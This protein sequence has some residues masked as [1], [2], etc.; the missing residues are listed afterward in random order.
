MIVA[1][2]TD[3]GPSRRRSA[4]NPTTS[5]KVQD[6]LR[7]DENGFIAARNP[8]KNTKRTTAAGIKVGLDASKK[9][10]TYGD[11]LLETLQ[12]LRAQVAELNGRARNN[13]RQFG[14]GTPTSGKPTAEPS[15]ALRPSSFP[16][17]G[18]TDQRSSRWIRSLRQ[19]FEVFEA[20]EGSRVAAINAL[21]DSCND[22]S[23][24][25]PRKVRIFYKEGAD[26]TYI[27]ANHTFT[28]DELNTGLEL[29]TDSRDVRR[30]SQDGKATIHLVVSDDNDQATDLV[31]LRVAPV[32]MHHHAQAVTKAFTVVATHNNSQVQFVSEC[33]GNIADAGIE[34]PVYFFSERIDRNIEILKRETGTADAEICRVPSLFYPGGGPSSMAVSILE[35]ATPPS[36]KSLARRQTSLGPRVV[37]LHPGTIN[38]V[39]VADSMVLAP[40]PWGSDINGKDT[41]ADAVSA[42]YVFEGWFQ[43]H[44]SE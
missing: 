14:S 21:L 41:L 29:G 3:Y 4:R 13:K 39:V 43:R 16:N 9:T 35:A 7:A 37:A 30:P 23:D 31:E 34:E 10:S 27:A 8:S 19:G 11:A 17:I 42:V 20:E 33:V 22:A 40:I 18:D 36:H 24:N 1:E 26:W 32:L 44:L 6:N 28:T 15:D 38:D 5:S 2:T 25:Q 12:R